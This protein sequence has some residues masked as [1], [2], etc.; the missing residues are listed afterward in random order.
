LAA[1]VLAIWRFFSTI[2]PISLRRSI[3]SIA[4]GR[5]GAGSGSNGLVLSGPGQGSP[6]GILP[7]APMA[8]VTPGG[9]TALEAL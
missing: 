8:D 4:T 9:V 6:P 1:I 7:S 2:E 3:A 5:A